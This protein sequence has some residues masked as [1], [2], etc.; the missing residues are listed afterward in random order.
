MKETRVLMVGARG[1]GRWHLKNI[2]ALQGQ[3]LRLVGVHH[4]LPEEP[5][6]RDDLIGDV[7]IDDDLPRLLDAT[8]PDI[9][10]V[11]TPIHTH[12]SLALQAV[13]HGSAVLLEKPP[14]PTLA[15]FDLL[16]AGAA[17]TACQVGFQS[18]GS[19]A[20]QA[21]RDVLIRGQIGELRGIGGAGTWIRE[22]AYFHRSPWAGHRYIDGVP[23]IDGVLTNPFAHAVATALRLIDTAPAPGLAQVEVDLYRAHD[24]E[25]DDTS[26][27]RLTTAGG[28]VI[29]L[30]ATLCPEVDREPYLVIHG[31]EGSITLWYTQDVMTVRTVNGSRTGR[32]SRTSLLANL[33]AHLVDAS[34]PLLVP[35]ASTR[36]FM[37]VAD[38]VAKSPDPGVIPGSAVTVIGSGSRRRL[39]VNGIDAAIERSASELALFRELGLPWAGQ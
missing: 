16:V 31:S 27:L 1:H 10:I 11:C 29:T 23:V 20:I 34:V 7:P 8:A 6:E 25:S 12:V 26:A 17:G 14:A 5:I 35:L 13:E 4:Y 30:A 9:T 32:Y 33:A 2:Q 37:Q 3:G 39:V 28:T 24:S 36:P 15:E 19:A 21:A 38:A 22:E 18:L